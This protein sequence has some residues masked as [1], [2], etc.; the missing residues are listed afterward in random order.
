MKHLLIFCAAFLLS[1]QSFAQSIW[2]M[3]LVGS[4]EYSGAE[5][6]D[7]WAYV[8]SNGTEYA[9]VGLTTG[10]S[11][12]NL[13]NPAVPVEEFQIP[14][15]NSIWRDI[16]VWENY[17]YVVADQGQDGLLIVDLNDMS[18]NTYA[19]SLVDDNGNSMF[20]HAHNI[21]IDEFGKAYIF[22]GDV[23]TIGGALI[24]DVTATDLSNNV[25]PTNLG[26]FDDFYL[27]DGMARG[28]TLWGAAINNGNLWAIDVSNPANPVVFNNGAAFHATP[29]NFTHNCWVSDDGKTVYTTDEKPDAYIA[30]YDVS[31]LNNIVELDR[32][33]SSPGQDVIPHNVHVMGDFLVSSY[34][35]DGIVIH[36]ATYPNNLI[37][38]AHYDTHPQNSGNGF[39]G[40]WGA[41]PWLPS[42][43]ILSMDI[44]S[45]STGLGKLFVL[46]STHQ[47]AC[48]LEGNVAD[49][50]SGAAIASASLELLGTNVTA[51]SN[52]IGDYTTG[53]A[54]PMIYGVRCS[55]PGY[56][57][58]T[59]QVTLSSGVLSVLD[60]SLNCDGVILDGT[61]RDTL[62]NSIP[63]ASLMF[64]NTDSSIVFNQTADANGS[65]LMECLPAGNYEVMV[66]S[67]GHETK[68][69]TALLSTNTTIDFAL[70]PMY[71]DDFTFDLGWTVNSTATAGIWERGE[72]NGTSYQSSPVQTEEDVQSDCYTQCYITG[73]VS[74]GSAGTDD[75]DDGN[76]ILTSP[77]F[78]LS[79]YATADISYY[80]WFENTGGSGGATNDSLIIALSNGTATETLEIVTSA[81][82]DLAQWVYQQHTIHIPLT[83]TMSL[84]VYTA[85]AAAG[86]LVEAAFD[87]FSVSGTIEEGPQSVREI[88][89][90]S[91][92]PNPIQD[93]LYVKSPYQGEVELFNLLGEKV[94]SFYKNDIDSRFPVSNLSSGVYI[95]QLGS[96][97]TK[98]IKE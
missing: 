47:Q 90:L 89:Q 4:Y 95:L 92:Y 39:D 51:N 31:D 30:A 63:G 62:G 19:F 44:N 36:D 76:T 67:W 65:Y 57:D 88:A 6:N 5:G 42:G 75:V 85:D 2:N 64:I 60:F 87:A 69:Q 55:A 41:Y 7:I 38:V 83:A 71:M 43:L 84:E 25:L 32:I 52:I 77:L 66:A 70:A 82:A 26:V 10:F 46:G 86:H 80:R 9:L 28:D 3:N 11:V 58:D 93:H 72:P 54:T 59:L 21:Y 91:V 23:G 33:Q 35:R 49:A 29:N 8:D 14:G 15:A 12:V 97:K 37:E 68:C 94:A 20:T 22:G 40:S 1:T 48:Y 18:G 17:A 98:I 34:Y 27:H 78:D 24:L 53:I 73:N 96:K 13:S 56:Q 79:N 50:Q 81:N 74:G 45:S 61:V 16:K